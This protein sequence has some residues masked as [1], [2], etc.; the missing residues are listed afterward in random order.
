[1]GKHLFGDLGWGVE[2]YQMLI[3]TTKQIN[4][5]QTKPKK[6]IAHNVNKTIYIT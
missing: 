2:L 4:N 5:K 6:T 3:W 1:M